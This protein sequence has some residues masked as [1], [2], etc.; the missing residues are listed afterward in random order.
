LPRVAVDIP[1]VAW[2]LAERF[3]PGAVTLVLKRAA[4]VPAIVS[5]GR[6]TVGVRVPDDPIANA[7]I[8]G[9]GRPITGTSANPTGAPAARTAD[10]VC[11]LLGARVDFVIDGGARPGG[12]PSTVLDLTGTVPSILRPGRVAIEELQPYLKP[13]LETGVSAG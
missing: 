12:Q 2:R 8:R 9:L 13:P 4:E 5:G 7:L 10:E 6:D 11:A 3:W 1:D